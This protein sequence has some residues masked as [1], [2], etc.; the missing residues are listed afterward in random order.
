M[1]LIIAIVFYFIG[2]IFIVDGFRF[3]PDYVTQQTI[4]YLSLLIGVVCCGFGSIILAMRHFSQNKEKYN[5]EEL[6]NIKQNIECIEKYLNN[7]N[8]YFSKYND[9]VDIDLENSKEIKKE[10]AM[11]KFKNTKKFVSSLERPISMDEIIL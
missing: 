11:E 3:D 5:N 6:G 1:L 2:A 10:I 8:N 4:Q 9:K 7:I